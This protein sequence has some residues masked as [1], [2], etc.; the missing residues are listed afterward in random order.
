[1]ERIIGSFKNTVSKSVFGPHQ[2]RIYD[3][4]LLTWTH[5]VIDKINSR[6]LI[7]EA[8][9]GITLTPNH[10]ILGFPDSHGDKINPDVSVQHQLSRCK[11]VLNLFNSL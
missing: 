7:L 2:L 6:P 10:I 5:L 4:E 9:L 11:I 1:M 3:K 8:P